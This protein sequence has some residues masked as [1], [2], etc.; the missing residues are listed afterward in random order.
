MTNSASTHRDTPKPGV[1]R[2]LRILVEA[3]NLF[4]NVFDD[5]IYFIGSISHVPTGD[6]T[7]MSV[8][9]VDISING[10]HMAQ[11]FWKFL[12]ALLERG[13]R[14]VW[15]VCEVPENVVSLWEPC[16]PRKEHP[17]SLTLDC[18]R[19]MRT[20]ESPDYKQFNLDIKLD[21]SI[22]SKVPMCSK[23][24]YANSSQVEC[25]DVSVSSLHKRFL[26]S[27]MILRRPAETKFGNLLPLIERL[28]QA[29]DESEPQ[30][31]Q[32]QQK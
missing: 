4:G 3:R 6:K 12:R 21:P 29:P 23:W 18:D 11:D 20:F 25:D 26:D 13:V 14:P 16:H 2:T 17:L 15:D 8:G 27:D 32:S 1:L 24:M 30:A 28:F 9:D 31:G 22:V 5:E 7:W 10:E 19:N